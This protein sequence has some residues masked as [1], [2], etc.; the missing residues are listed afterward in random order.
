[1]AAVLSDAGESERESLVRAFERVHDL[2][3]RLQDEQR[4]IAASA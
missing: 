2:S 3:G 1:M 4:R